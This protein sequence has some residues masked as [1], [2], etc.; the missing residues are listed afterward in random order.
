MQHLYIDGAKYSAWAAGKTHMY[1]SLIQTHSASCCKGI[2]SSLLHKAQHAYMVAQRLLLHRYVRS[3]HP[4]PSSIKG[5]SCR[6]RYAL[7]LEARAGCV[8]VQLCAAGCCCAHCC[9]LVDRCPQQTRVA[10]TASP[11]LVP[12]CL[13]S[14]LTGLLCT[15]PTR[16]GQSMSSHRLAI[17][18]QTGALPSILSDHHSPANSEV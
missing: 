6:L 2:S 4:E 14:H 18:F 5:T 1:S 8:L 15:F 7:T 11:A 16:L 13:H 17:Q 9:I 10:C 3:G 12:A